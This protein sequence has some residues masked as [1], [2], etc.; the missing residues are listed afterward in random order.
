M[1]TQ[2]LGRVKTP[3]SA[4][5]SEAKTGPASD[6]DRGDQRFDP[7]DIHCSGQII[8]QNREGHLGGYLWESFG[9]EVRRSHASLHRAERMLDCLATK[10]HSERVRIEPMLHDVEQILV[11][12]SRDPSL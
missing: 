2:G 6:R 9:Q 4:V 11:L 8:G 10:A 7:E 1:S 5:G 3:D 12:P